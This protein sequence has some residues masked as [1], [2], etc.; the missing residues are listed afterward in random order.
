[1]KLSK[2]I[3]LLLFLAFTFSCTK[4]PK[5]SVIW[6]YTS[7]YKHVINKITPLLEK[8]F[9]EAE[10]QWYQSGSENIA[11]R[12][13]AELTTGK[14]QADLILTSDPLWYLELKKKD[15]LLQYKS[16]LVKNLA[17]DFADPDGFFT[18]VRVC[19]GLIGKNKEVSPT[20]KTWKDLW[21]PSVRGKL[22]MGN[23]MESGTALL[24]SM[25][26]YKKYGEE[27]LLKLRKNDIVAAGG[28]SA[29]LNR[30][31]SKEKPFGILLL[32][33]ILEA[34]GKN[35]P[36]EIIY[37][38]DGAVLIP[39]PM[40]ITKT[41]MNSELMKKIYDYFLEEEIQDTIIAGN[42]YSVIF[43]EKTPVGGKKLKDIL[44]NS[45]PWS[46][47]TLTKLYEDKENFKTKFSTV[48]MN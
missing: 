3:L 9:P 11:V 41:T 23:P 17:G 42:M 26:L 8:K 37:P 25:Q 16:P 36:V 13:N 33:N 29:V 14:T 18:T 28:N 35:S 34:Q 38:E 4:K 40:A 24:I 12:V 30:M 19:V 39:S 48:I 7:L 27:F 6:I 45:L 15:V 47:E 10:F 2:F 22:S 21:Q 44:N 32:E 46:H 43:P 31:E 5:R 20:I 1:M